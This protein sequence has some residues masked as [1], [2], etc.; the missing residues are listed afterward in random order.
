MKSREEP[1]DSTAPIERYQPDPAQGL[2]AGQAAKR[3][4]EGLDNQAVNPP[5]KTVGQIIL[6]NVL[7]FFNLIFFIL[8]GCLILV[9]SYKNLLF[10]LVVVA[11]ILI[12]IV[13]EIRAKRVIDRLTLLTAP[14]AAVIRDGE[15]LTLPTEQLVLDDVAL[16]TPGCQI[17]ADAVVL[18]GAVQVNE[19]LITGEARSV[20]RGP[21][22]S[23]LSG[24][25]I[26]AGSCRARLDRVGADSYASR[27]T[28]EAKRRGR[29][30]ESEMMRS[31][32]RLVQGIAVV[33]LPIGAAMLLRHL[34]QLGMPLQQSMEATIAALVGMIPEGLYLLTSV[35][36]AVGVIRLGRRHTLVHELSCIETLARVDVLCVDKTG[37]ITENEMRVEQV[38]PLKEGQMNAGEVR[39]VLAAYYQ[40]V[41]ADNSTAR[42]MHD[43]FVSPRNG[44]KPPP[45][46]TEAVVPFSSVRKWSAVTFAQQGTYLVGA[47]ECIL[48]RDGFQPLR[49]RTA[50]LAAAGSRVLLLARYGH[51]P[52]NDT[53]HSPAEPL[54]LITLGNPIRET[55]PATF[56]F[57]AEQ[58]VAV[59]VI[60]GDNPLT[61]SEVAGRA[62]IAGAEQAV[63]ASVL[64]DGELEAAAETANVFGR[65]TP[66][67]K[68]L[69]VRA[70]KKAGHTV[71]M[72]GDGVNDVL[73]LKDAD[74]SIAMAAGSDAACHVS[75]LVLLNSDFASLP[76]VVMEGRRV[77]NNIERAASL[78][79]VKTI[80]SLLLALVTLFIA[81]PYPVK[82]IQLSLIS[83]LTIGLPA[84]FLALEPN[85]SQTKGRF[86]L[87][88]VG[89]ALPG[90]LT[91]LF[92]LLGVQLFTVVFGFTDAERTTMSTVILATV[93]LLVLYQ[94]CKPFNAKHSLIWIGMA[95]GL[96]AAIFG[97]SDFFMLTPLS[98]EA[99]LILLLFLLL[100]YSVMHF[101]LWC[102]ER[103]HQAGVCWKK[104]RQNRRYHG[105]QWGGKP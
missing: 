21:G 60:S 41:G 12:G 6:S 4:E 33:I 51:T 99:F 84:F 39:T 20:S 1:L 82:P 73:A 100:A 37:T 91:N 89:R 86:L 64:S 56:H 98:R 15:T 97:F 8:A 55:A 50:A 92:L 62:G 45:W 9:G 14:Q 68:R 88:V 72:T 105:R 26:T 29:K 11:N 65:V 27:L 90:G 57:F 32:T 67:Q 85:H 78:F 83:S 40:A 95:A 81:V 74:C 70:L 18:E 104:R 54:A 16:F 28:V 46:E 94:V 103:G 42:A 77:I 58:G 36:L 69:L 10:L 48:N 35:A 19:A 80:F 87:N 47:P 49:E 31:L 59:K 43:S 13:Q 76:A 52:Q 102:F 44:P 75:Q 63:D 101:F 79:L 61:V 53:L 17:C 30:H 38:I 22:D 34:F 2:T 66:D 24:S 71:A 5:S 23:L 3:R 93:G 96:T 7:T 25:F